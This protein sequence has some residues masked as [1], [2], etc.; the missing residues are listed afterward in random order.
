MVQKLT[1]ARPTPAR[2]SEGILARQTQVPASVP[3]SG[4]RSDRDERTGGRFTGKRR[5]RRRRRGSAEP[6]PTSPPHCRGTRSRKD[7]VQ[8]IVTANEQRADSMRSSTRGEVQRRVAPAA[9][10][11]RDNDMTVTGVVAYT[12][13]QRPNEVF[14]AGREPALCRWRQLDEKS[15]IAA[16]APISRAQGETKDDIPRELE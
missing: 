12:I 16:G 11:T 1:G 3:R 14:R 7:D 4:A 2:S 10:V 15:S 6:T 13:L 9:D 5:R 8:V